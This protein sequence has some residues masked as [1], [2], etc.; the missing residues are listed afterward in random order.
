MKTNLYRLRMDA[1]YTSAAKFAEAAGLK[2]DTYRNY[3]NSNC[4]IPL[5]NAVKIADFLN[6][7]L[8][9][10]VERKRIS[11]SRQLDMRLDD[12]DYVMKCYKMLEDSDKKSINK[13]ILSLYALS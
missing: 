1:G 9:E 8:D 7:S 13:H 11:P 5:D 2:I 10:L 12:Q 4:R 6:C 3:E